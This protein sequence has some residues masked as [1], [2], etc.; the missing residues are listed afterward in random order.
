MS[1]IVVHNLS[2]CYSTGKKSILWS[3][4]KIVF[5][6]EKKRLEKQIQK[7]IKNDYFSGF[8]LKKTFGFPQ[9]T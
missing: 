4:I 6:N 2:A 5:F 3:F 7:N 9:E 1:D 8:A